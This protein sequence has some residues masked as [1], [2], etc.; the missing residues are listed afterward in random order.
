MIKVEEEGSFERVNGD[1]FCLGY[2][3]LMKQMTV[4][5]NSSGEIRVALQTITF[6]SYETSV[7]QSQ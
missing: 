1:H 4:P 3:H 2:E 7:R 5:D 6:F